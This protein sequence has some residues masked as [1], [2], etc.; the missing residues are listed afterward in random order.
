ML[1]K[2]LNVN[3]LYFV[4]ITTNLAKEKKKA[5][6]ITRGVLHSSKLRM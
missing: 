4:D 6:Y 5:K 1:V 3:I 2:A